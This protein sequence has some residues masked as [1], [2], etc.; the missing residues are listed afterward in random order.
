MSVL[1]LEIPA[2]KHISWW[3][4]T[5]NYKQ[6]FQVNDFSALK[7]N[8]FYWWILAWRIPWTEKPGRLQSIGSKRVR[9][10]SGDSAGRTHMVDL[11]CRVRF[12]CTERWTT[13][14]YIYFFSDSFPI[15]KIT[16]YWVEFPTLY[17][18][19]SLAIYFIHNNVHMSIPISQ[20]IP[21]P[22]LIPW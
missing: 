14:T 6:I 4:I 15:Q 18:M 10:D 16:E 5:A 11:Q 21:L 3:N 12:R 20:F 17:S 1:G 22:L 2:V 7:K 9:Q 13:Y 8:F 19:F